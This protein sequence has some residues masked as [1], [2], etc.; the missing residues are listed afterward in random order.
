MPTANPTSRTRTPKTTTGG[1][2]RG[3]VPREPQGGG[4]GGG[5]GD[6]DHAPDYLEQLRKYRLG[7]FFTLVPI[8]ML[9]VLL[10]MVFV[11]RRAGERYDAWTGR[12]ISDWVSITLPAKLLL[13]NT[14]ILLL[15]SLT[16]ERARRVAVLDAILI[17]ASRIAG[18]K[19]IEEKSL[20]WVHA[21][22]CLG[23]CFLG[24]Q[25][26][27]WRQLEGRGNSVTSGLASSFVYLLTGAHAVHLAGGLLVLLYASFGRILG[28]SLESR[29]ITIDVTA[30]YWHFMGALWIYILVV[31]W[32]VH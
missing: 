23:L 27:A 26:L 5:R 1:G 9:F 16:M 32:F 15:S 21:T 3:P 11:A 18:I 8:T 17:P 10:T 4:G 30:L 12:F 14:T 22:A 6:G 2:G 20:R 13:I 7:L 25:W 31:L 19:R 29:R 24:G 28:K